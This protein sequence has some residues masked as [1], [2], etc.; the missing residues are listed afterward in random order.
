MWDSPIFQYLPLCIT[1]KEQ[2]RLKDLVCKLITKNELCFLFVF[3]QPEGFC[4]T[5]EFSHG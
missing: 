3:D 4:K 5:N 2:V 1:S